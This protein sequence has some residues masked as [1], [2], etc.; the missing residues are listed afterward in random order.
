MLFLALTVKPIP[1]VAEKVP[2]ENFPV[3]N[4]TS[5]EVLPTP[6]SPSNIVCKQI[7]IKNKQTP[8]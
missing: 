1:T 8:K 6:L 5:R 2:D 3:S 7:E 4:L